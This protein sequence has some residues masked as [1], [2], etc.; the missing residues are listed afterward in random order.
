M[1]KHSSTLQVGD[2][3]PDFTL[4]SANGNDDL[5]LS[6]L[7]QRGPMVIEFLRGTW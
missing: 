4:P 5:A 7:V 1:T 2:T 6:Q 3:A